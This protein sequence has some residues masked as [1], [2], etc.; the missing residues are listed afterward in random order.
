MLSKERG[1][2]VVA[3]G[4][5]VEVELVVAVLGLSALTRTLQRTVEALHG[6]PS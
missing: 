2:E 4:A 3:E 5:G 6:A 1:F